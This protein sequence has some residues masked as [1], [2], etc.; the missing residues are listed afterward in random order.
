VRPLGRVGVVGPKRAARLSVP[1]IA[2]VS[3]PPTRPCG[4]GPVSFNYVDRCRQPSFAGRMESS[5]LRR[6]RPNAVVLAIPA[7]RRESRETLPGHVSEGG[8]R[9]VSI[10]L[11][12]RRDVPPDRIDGTEDALHLP[13]A[14]ARE[15]ARC[16]FR[17]RRRR[18]RSSNSKWSMLRPHSSEPAP[19]LW[20]ISLGSA[21]V[22][23]RP[24]ARSPHDSR[25]M[26][27]PVPQPARP[28]F[29]SLWRPDD[30][31]CVASNLPSGRRPVVPRR[32]G[33]GSL[34]AP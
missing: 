9:R 19:K 10:S 33:L 27:S 13:L 23:T 22:E 2:L 5:R 28:G 30:L 1:S 11:L 26:R 17:E 12:D 21:G 4:G 3:F 29:G 14:L 18:T 34:T 24:L 6:E 31:G 32:R 8:P 20:S 7:R 25:R 16:R 15:S